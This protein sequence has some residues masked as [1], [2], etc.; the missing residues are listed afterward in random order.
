MGN[1]EFCAINTAER[2]RVACNRSVLRPTGAASQLR[3]STEW[4]YWTAHGA[5]HR[6]IPGP[7]RASLLP[8]LTPRIIRNRIHKRDT[9][10]G[11]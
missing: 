9:E 7:P 6:I 8:I 10:E 5:L 1:F 11:A 3:N 2:A 4:N